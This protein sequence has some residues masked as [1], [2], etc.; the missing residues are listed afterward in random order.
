LDFSNISLLLAI[1]QVKWD[2]RMKNWK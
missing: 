2:R 1:L